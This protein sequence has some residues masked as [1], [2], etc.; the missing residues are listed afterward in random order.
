MQNFLD[1]VNRCPLFRDINASELQ[2]LL[3]CLS[4][5]EKHYAKNSFVFIAGDNVTSI[6]IVLSGCVHIVQEDFWGNRTILTAIET[7]GMF[8][9]AFSCAEIEKFPVSVIAIQP[10][11][12]LLIDYKKIATICSSA[13]A[14]HAAL[15][16]NML[17]I[18]ANKNVMLTQKIESLTKRTT[19]EKLLSYLSLEA[20][21]ANANKFTIPYNRQE[22]AEYLSVDRSAMSNELSKM[23]DEGIL[24]FE[25]SKFEL[26]KTY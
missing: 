18:L 21:R 10:S 6:G 13:C 25:R 20:Q 15:I 2:K 5:V 3:S 22:L 26:Y 14:Y 19:R 9:E 17:Q 12:I 1:I 7:G 16:K 4:A 24:L 11:D 8:G 23:R